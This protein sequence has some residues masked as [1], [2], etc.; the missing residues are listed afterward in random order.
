MEFFATLIKYRLPVLLQRRVWSRTTDFRHPH[1]PPP[2]THPNLNR[3]KHPDRGP[4][5]ICGCIVIAK[6]TDKYNNHPNRRF[7]TARPPPSALSTA[8]KRTR[9]WSMSGRYNKKKIAERDDS[10]TG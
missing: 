2:P 5:L 1:F 3:L 10:A 4:L 6:Y 9:L 7:E 8:Q